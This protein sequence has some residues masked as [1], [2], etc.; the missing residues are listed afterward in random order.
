MAETD[1]A[2]K[3][4][5]FSEVF[6]DNNIFVVHVYF[7]FINFFLSICLLHNNIYIYIYTVLFQ[8]NFK[9]PHLKKTFQP[10]KTFSLI[11]KNQF[12]IFQ[13]FT[14]PENR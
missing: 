11:L 5:F 10:Q 6:D 8:N 13:L 12:S 3:E 4:N 2:G 7:L 1:I 9:L 14:E